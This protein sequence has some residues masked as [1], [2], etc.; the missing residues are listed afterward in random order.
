[1]FQFPLVGVNRTQAGVLVPVNRKAFVLLPALDRA[2]GNSKPGGDFLP[3]VEPV[4]RVRP[5]GGGILRALPVL[6]AHLS[7]NYTATRAKINVD[8]L[9]ADFVA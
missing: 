9:L 3:G 8:L 1:L 7:G 5:G 4:T 2:Y 6:H